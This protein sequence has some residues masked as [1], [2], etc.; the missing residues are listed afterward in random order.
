MWMSDF[1]DDSPEYTAYWTD[2][3]Y[4]GQWKLRPVRYRGPGTVRTTC[5]TGAKLMFCFA[6][7]LWMPSCS[8]LGNAALV[9][10]APRHL[11][12]TIG[13]RWRC[14]PGSGWTGRWPAAKWRGVQIASSR[15]RDS[16][17]D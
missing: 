15:I 3:L 1:R 7:D 2:W 11:P 6:M 10:R 9:S 8:N 12:L 14:S 16:T 17:R 4:I 5:A 13:N